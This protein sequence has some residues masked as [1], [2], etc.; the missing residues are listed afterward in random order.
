MASLDIPEQM[1]VPIQVWEGGAVRVGRTRV[2][3]WQVVGHHLEGLT[4]EQMVEH[5][6]TLELADVYGAIAY[7]LANREAVD[8]YLAEEERLAEELHQKIVS[9]PGYHE[10]VARLKARHAEMQ[11]GTRS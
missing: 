6:P 11:A 2:N 1:P 5:Y 4:P 10:A 8:A 7:Y 9:Q 3:L